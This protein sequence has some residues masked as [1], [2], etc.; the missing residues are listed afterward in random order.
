MAI[1]SSIEPVSKPALQAYWVLR[2]AFTVVPI[3]AG[4]DQF[5]GKLANWDMYLD[6][7]PR[8]FCRSLLTRS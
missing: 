4:I 1:V 7:R 8:V 3:I 2:I 6:P 5:T